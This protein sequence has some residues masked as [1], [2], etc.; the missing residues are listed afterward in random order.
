MSP[1]SVLQQTNKGLT[2]EVRTDSAALDRCS[3][4]DTRCIPVEGRAIS[5][6]G[7]RAMRTEAQRKH[8]AG[9]MRRWR[10]AHLETARKISR[11]ANRRWSLAHPEARRESQRRWN[12]THPD[13]YRKWYL[14]HREE[15]CARTKNRRLAH[16]EENAPHSARRRAK[17]RRAECS[18]TVAEWQVVKS[19]YGHR[20]VYCKRKL[21][22]LTMDHVIPLS[23]GGSHTKENVV[24]A[25]SRCN[26][27]K[28][29]NSAPQF[30]RALL[31]E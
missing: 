27:S 28:G 6:Y 29:A 12:A 4:L 13:F 31:L 9:Y 11:E 25:C 1:F 10:L 3:L 24:P 23:R 14:A 19:I 7:E 8:L 16:P 17:Q 22:R 20:C 26:S 2:V 21:K 15:V 30:Q 5:T 18:L